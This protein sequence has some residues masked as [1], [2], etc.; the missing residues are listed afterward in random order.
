MS[1]PTLSKVTQWYLRKKCLVQ[2]VHSGYLLKKKAGNCF[3]QTN[4]MVHRG[5]QVSTSVTAS[6]LVTSNHQLCSL[7]P[8]G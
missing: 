3:Y 5:N 1:P 7:A 6:A 2:E 8:I 4:N